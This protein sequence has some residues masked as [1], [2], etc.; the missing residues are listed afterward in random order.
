MVYFCGFGSYN[1][2]AFQQYFTFNSLGLFRPN[3]AQMHP[4]RNGFKIYDLF[5]PNAFFDGIYNWRYIDSAYISRIWKS[6][7]SRIVDL[8]QLHLTKCICLF[9]IKWYTFKTQFN[10]YE[11]RTL[12]C[13]IICFIYPFIPFELV[14]SFVVIFH[15]SN[16]DWFLKIR[17]HHQR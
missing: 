1:Q 13:C 10:K 8:F 5:P 4:R 11:K 14:Y 9:T 12:L 16:K 6:F 17:F 15:K 2:R 3:L 7:S